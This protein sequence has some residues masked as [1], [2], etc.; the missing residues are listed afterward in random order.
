MALP[1]AGKNEAL[2]GLL[3]GT[4]YIA[5]LLANDTELS[6]HGY[7]RKAI[8][9]SSWT[10]TGGV[11]TAAVPLEIYTATDGSAQQAGKAQIFDA[12]TTGNALTDAVTLSPLPAAPSN[13]GTFR[14]TTLTVTA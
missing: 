12:A 1:D 2:Q 13:G 4:R 14:L 10:I 7:A 8:A 6:G 5:L 11:A 9:L 3:D